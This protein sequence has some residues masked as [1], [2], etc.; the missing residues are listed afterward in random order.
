ME[1]IGSYISIVGLSSLFS[2][3]IVII[4][5]AGILD[6]A[7]I[8]SVS[9]L[10]QYWNEIRRDM[11]YYMTSAVLILMIIT[12]G[13]AFGYLSSAFQKAVQPNLE[14]SLK[15]DA[16]A[17]QQTTLISEKKELSELKLSINKQIA[18]I[19]TENERSRRQLIASMKPELDR[20]S[21]RLEQVNNQLDELSGKSLA[22][23]NDNLVK[24]VHTG[25][26]IYISKAF[27]VSVEDSS[28]YIIGVIV[29][30]FDPL[31]VVL[32][33]A[34][35]FLILKKR[36]KP[37]EETS[38]IINDFGTLDVLDPLPETEH[39]LP[40]IEEPVVLHN[41]FCMT[42]PEIQPETL[43]LVESE[44]II[45]PEPV[46]EIAPTESTPE[47]E[48]ELVPISGPDAA[49]AE[50]C[51]NF[52]EAWN[53]VAPTIETPS[54]DVSIDSSYTGSPQSEFMHEPLPA[55]LK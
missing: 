40:I 21:K 42:E 36:L 11:K 29:G 52:A 43:A 19:P 37:K 55:S 20:T 27:G 44:P 1:G 41:D 17:A 10:Y 26:I 12:S 14:A 48:L 22:A 31:A 47:Q 18:A 30:V 4:L 39:P 6:I 15:V 7:K 16:F 46:P 53:Q 32:I 8:T 3:D 51:R 9:F 28:K 23:K 33:L 34:A 13:G 5:M 35:N 49:L 25:P 38:P 54:V 2:G 45:E 50:H 24:D